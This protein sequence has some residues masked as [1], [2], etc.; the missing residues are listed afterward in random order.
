M[1]ATTGVIY[2]PKTNLQLNANF[3][4][5]WRAPHVSELFSNGVHHGSASFEVGDATMIPE[6]AYN[7]IAGLTYNTKNQKLLLQTNIYCNLINNFIYLQP[8]NTTILTVRGAFPVFAY[9]QTNALLTGIDWQMSY[10]LTQTLKV[11]HKGSYL[12]AYDRKQHQF[13][14]MM[15][16]TRLE[17]GAEYQ[18]HDTKHFTDNYVSVSVQ[19]VFE[20]KCTT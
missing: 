18:L 2:Y 5:A 6:K 17:T 13:L 10:Q 3:G 20:Q 9:K 14:V 15:P 1:S 16:P 4:T 19:T 11:N 12:Y 7:T 8:Q